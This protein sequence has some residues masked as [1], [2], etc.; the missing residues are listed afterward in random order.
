MKT[1]KNPVDKNTLLKITTLFRFRRITDLL[2]AGSLYEDK[3]FVAN[4][5][6]VQYQIYML[7][8]YLEGQWDLKKK[9]INQYW[10][11]I[12]SALES[13]GYST[14][15]IAP[16]VREIEMYEKIECDCRKDK[17][18]TKRSMK[19]YYTVKSCDVRLIRHLI[20]KAK[21][22]LKQLWKEKSWKPF[23]LITEV[24][25]DVADI[26]EDLKTYNVNRYLISILR[27]GGEKTHKQYQSFLQKNILKAKDLFETNSEYGKNKILGKWTTDRG[28]QTLRLLERT[29][30]A[31]IMDEL[32]GSLLL[33]KMK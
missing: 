15:E 5:I 32:S 33:E 9:Q 23:D 16:M 18:P 13:M 27:K 17:W 29:A 2:K 24:N 30:R 31:K 25:D 10:N 19:E 12:F 1:S 21:P 26:K 8:S 20:Y 6:N 14:K 3:E 22:E 11:R 28:S 4:L 7:D